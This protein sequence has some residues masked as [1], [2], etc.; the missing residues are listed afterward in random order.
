VSLRLGPATPILRIFDEAKA[1]EFYLDFLGFTWDWEHRFSPDL[2]LFVQV[3]RGGMRLFLSE[4]HG[5]GTPGTKIHITA[6]GVD[7]FHAELHAK[8]Y[9]Y[10]RP[11]IEDMPWGERQ[12][13][14]TDPFGN[15][16]I[17]AE[18]KKD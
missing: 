2:P 8:Q 5:D 9:R 7:A 6:E 12:V 16:L 17:F 3:S 18:P 13:Q 10:Y 15:I 4:H 1:R 11:G 14:V